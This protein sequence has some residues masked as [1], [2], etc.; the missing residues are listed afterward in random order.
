MHTLL[1]IGGKTKQPTMPPHSCGQGYFPAWHG[2]EGGVSC[3]EGVSRCPPVTLATLSYLYNISSTEVLTSPPPA[4][5]LLRRSWERL[6]MVLALI[7]HSSLARMPTLFFPKCVMLVSALKKTVRSTCTVLLTYAVPAVQ[8]LSV[9]GILS[10]KKIQTK[11]LLPPKPCSLMPLCSMAG[12]LKTDWSRL[13]STHAA[14]FC[15][16]CLS[17]SSRISYIC[18]HVS[19]AGFHDGAEV[20]SASWALKLAF[21]IL[22]AKAN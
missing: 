21:T 3:T 5:V 11:V 2:A 20:D 13:A 22:L 14:H 8:S 18:S 16:I 4:W 6:K 19:W 15:P 9:C 17:S 1:I 10:L 7:I 12:R